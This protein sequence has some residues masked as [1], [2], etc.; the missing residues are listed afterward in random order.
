MPW[1]LS[2]VISDSPMLFEPFV[3]SAKFAAEYRNHHWQYVRI[4]DSDRKIDVPKG[5][6]PYPAKSD[7]IGDKPRSDSGGNFGRLART[8]MM[9][10]Y[11]RKFEDIP[12]CGIKTIYWREFLKAFQEGTTEEKARTALI[13]L[14]NRVQSLA[15]IP[16][17]TAKSALL[18]LAELERL[19]DGPQ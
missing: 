6:R 17:P 1:V 2:N 4:T 10:E 15:D 14:R 8:K 13:R 11:M 19:L 18:I 5:I 3:E 7:P 9:D 16:S 12:L